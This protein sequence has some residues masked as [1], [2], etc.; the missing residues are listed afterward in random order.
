[1]GLERN[2]VLIIKGGHM[3]VSSAIRE[4]ITHLLPQPNNFYVLLKAQVDSMMK[5]CPILQDIAEQKS[6][7]PE[8]RAEIKQIEE[9]CDSRTHAVHKELQMQFI[10]PIDREDIGRL[11]KEIDDAVDLVEEAIQL[12]VNYNVDFSKKPDV[13]MK[14]LLG[15]TVASLVNVYEAVTRLRGFRDIEPIRDNM[16]TQEHSADTLYE[17]IRA[18]EYEIDVNIILTTDDTDWMSVDDYKKIREVEL[19]FRKRTAIAERLEDAVDSCKAIFDI[20]NDIY[21]KHT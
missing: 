7:K 2:F 12:V 1:M 9:E 16:R 20:L 4:F 6:F 21:L 5:A 17:T 3:S 11:T 8:W 13:E 14:T 10:T 18:Q 19:D 15:V